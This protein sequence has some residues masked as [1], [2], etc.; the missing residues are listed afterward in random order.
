[1]WIRRGDAEP[2]S[3]WS[4][5]IEARTDAL[6]CSAVVDNADRLKQKKELARRVFSSQVVGDGYLWFCV[7]VLGES[8]IDVFE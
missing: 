3:R 5:L 8:Q 1:M 6:S 2:A 4:V 7:C